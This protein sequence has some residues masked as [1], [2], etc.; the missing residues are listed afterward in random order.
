[1]S[2]IDTW[3]IVTTV[4]DQ[5]P[6]RDRTIHLDPRDPVRA[7]SAKACA[8]EDAVAVLIAPRISFHAHQ[9]I[10]PWILLMVPPSKTVGPARLSG[11]R[12]PRAS[13][14]AR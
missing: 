13:N 4:A 9:A 1:M 11:T 12:R 7:P 6:G 8:R 14:L 3:R 2:N 5:H 10:H